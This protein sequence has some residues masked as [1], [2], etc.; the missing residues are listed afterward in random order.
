MRTKLFHILETL[1]AG[2]P[3]YTAIY[4]LWPLF[5]YCV[6]IFELE[7]RTSASRIVSKLQFNSSRSVSLLYV[8]L[9][10]KITIFQNVPPVIEAIKLIWAKNLGRLTNSW[11]EHLVAHT[12]EDAFG[13][14]SLT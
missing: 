4:P 12:I 6:T 3:F 2:G 10:H 14:L 1:P 7:Q 8:I 5:I 13:A 11:W 9:L